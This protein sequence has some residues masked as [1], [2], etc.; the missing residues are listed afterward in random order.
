M[1]VSLCSC[2]SVDPRT[3]L[4][5]RNSKG[6]LQEESGNKL[7]WSLCTLEEAFTL[8]LPRDHSILCVGRHHMIFLT[9]CWSSDVDVVQLCRCLMWSTHL[10]PVYGNCM[11]FTG[12]QNHSTEFCSVSSGCAWTSMA[13]LH[14]P[15]HKH[16]HLEPSFRGNFPIRT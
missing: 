14:T 15:V 4:C 1:Q 16:C 9:L 8:R 7:L 5:M 3:C 10:R 13:L 12:G 6:S 2:V 11:H